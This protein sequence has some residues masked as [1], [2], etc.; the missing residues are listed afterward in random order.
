MV[1]DTLF[2]LVA[3]LEELK[4][5]STAEVTPYNGFASV[6]LRSTTPTRPTLACA[7]RFM[8]FITT[9]LVQLRKRNGFGNAGRPSK[10][11]KD[12]V[13]AER[14]AGP[15]RGRRRRKSMQQANKRKRTDKNICLA[16]GG[17]ATDNAPNPGL[18]YDGYTSTD[19]HS[20]DKMKGDWRLTGIGL[21]GPSNLKFFKPLTR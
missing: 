7:R 11:V 20:G 1:Y 15:S 8:T 9:R 18:D 2:R 21:T 14:P 19:S 12:K 13:D 4:K 17:A 5:L 10:I 6:W 3:A 16:G